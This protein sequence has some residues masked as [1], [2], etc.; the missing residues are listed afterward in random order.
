MGIR[1]TMIPSQG[2]EPHLYIAIE[3]VYTSYKQIYITARDR[4]LEIFS[5]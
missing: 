5:Y 4:E 1:L 3:K 2:V